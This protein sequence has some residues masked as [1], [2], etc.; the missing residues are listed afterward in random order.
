MTAREPTGDI[1]DIKRFA[2]H[3]G[4]GIRTTVFFRGCP[5]KCWWCHNPEA[6]TDCGGAAYSRRAMDMTRPP[7]EN[8][9]GPEVKLSNLVDEIERDSIF[10]DESHGGV[11][12]SGGEPLMQIDFLE[13]MLS[14]C[15]DRGISTSVDTS[16]YAPWEILEGLI[17]LVD[18]FLVDLKLMDET[19]HEKYTGVPNELIID[20]FTRLI[21]AGAVVRARLPMI[22]GITDTDENIDSLTSFL[23]GIVELERI[24]ILPYNRLGED[25]F[26]RI[27]LEYKPG[28]LRTQSREELNTI[29]AR[30]EKAGLKV[31]IGG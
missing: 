16:A 3:D 24:S 29:A 6:R 22:P 2:I 13:R 20:N 28:S 11:T 10:F 1:F 7:S 27:K 30:F 19:K 31:R 5:L 23:G 18:L 21:N 15:R 26:K 25:K 17:D 4:P 9:I 12:A 8:V 14:A